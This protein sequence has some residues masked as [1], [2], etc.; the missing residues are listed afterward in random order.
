MANQ[1]QKTMGLWS[2]T[3]MVIGSI[4]GAGIFMRPATMAGQLGSPTLMLTVWVIA[5]VVSLFGAM[6][7]A[8]LG[9]MYP[10]TGGPY[11]YLQEMYGELPA[12]LYGWSSLVVINTASL[13][14]FAFVC[15]DYA[16]WFVH[17]PR[18]DPAIEHAVKWHIPFLADIY[19]LE[20]FGTKSLAILILLL[21]TIV[22]YRTLRGGNAIQV[23]ATVLKALALILVIGGILL[24]GK[25]HVANFITNAPGLQVQPW[26][27]FTAV[28]AATSGAF[29]TYDGWYTINMMSG[30]VIDPRRN[31]SR[32]LF[33]GLGACIGI[34]LL[35]NLAY[36]YVLP[37][38]T[39]AHSNLVAAD[40]VNT[41]LGNSGA[42]LAAALIIISCFGAAQNNFIATARVTFLMGQT[43]DFFAWTGRVQPKYG[44]PGNALIIMG[45][46]SMLF[47]LSGSFDIMADMFVFM[48]WV[49]Y[50]LTAIGL[51]ILRRKRPDLSRSYS[52]GGYPW[53]PVLFILFTLFYLST[54]IYNDIT[55][56]R[57]GKAPIINSVFGL[58]L[59]AAGIPFYWYFQ[60]QKRKA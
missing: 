44:T 40:A 36:L 38:S 2:A 8:E 28:M 30:E 11:V 58:V 17:L 53:L 51:F 5:G 6:I 14:S 52:V 34:Y 24:S 57:T 27:M 1:L 55:A 42:A 32:S 56:Y 4:I 49:F 9:G 60:R 20:N 46:W 21:L 13:A 19:P 37:V 48:S 43:G 15:A 12:F 54:T 16:G 3:S 10:E 59:T 23:I 45:V 39:M 18:F 50:G 33:L 25:G 7:Y 31:I 35:A 47:I 26:L 22:N 41:V 29:S